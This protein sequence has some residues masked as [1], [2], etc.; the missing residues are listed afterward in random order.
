MWRRELTPVG[1][2][3][4]DFGPLPWLLG[5]LR[6]PFCLAIAAKAFAGPAQAPTPSTPVLRTDC[7]CAS[8]LEVHSWIVAAWGAKSGVVELGTLVS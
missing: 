2:V 1:Q 3:G 4:K 8:L 7:L 5:F 6:N